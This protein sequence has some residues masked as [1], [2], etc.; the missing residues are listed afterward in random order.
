MFYLNHL[1]RFVKEKTMLAVNA[2]VKK[3]VG[4]KRQFSGTRFHGHGDPD[5]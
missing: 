2:G 4:V 1:L 5:T 3:L